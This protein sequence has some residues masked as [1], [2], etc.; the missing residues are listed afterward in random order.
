MFLLSQQGVDSS[1]TEKEEHELTY[2]RERERDYHKHLQRI[3]Y[4]YTCI[5]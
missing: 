5:L 3:F 4:V 2:E 1:I